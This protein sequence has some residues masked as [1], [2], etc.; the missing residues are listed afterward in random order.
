MPD[1]ARR[2]L[3][4]HPMRRHSLLA[5]TLAACVALGACGTSTT[6]KGLTTT[7]PDTTTVQQQSSSSWQKAMPVPS[8]SAKMVC[9]PAA[10]SEIASSLGLTA[11]RVTQ[12]TWDQAHHVYA[13]TYVY[14]KGNITLSVKEMSSEAETNAYFD[15]IEHLAGKVEDLFGLGQ[16]AAILKNN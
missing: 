14:P 10:Q 2:S 1:W 8:S 11:T 13:C 4:W 15:G 3:R 6:S 9:Q 16:G 5:L 7:P 12:P